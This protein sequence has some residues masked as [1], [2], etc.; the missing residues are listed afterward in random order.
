M[1]CELQYEGIV[2]QVGRYAVA[3]Q[4]EDF[5]SPTDTIPMSSIPVQFIV[6]IFS[7]SQSCSSNDQPE[8]VG[9]TP[10]DGSCIGAPFFSPWSAVIT[11]RIPYN[12]SAASIIELITASPLGLI[13]S[14]P[15]H[16]GNLRE[17]QIT[18]TW[19]PSLSQSG[20]NVFCFAA[21]DNTK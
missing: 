5:V 20:P 13:K 10:K 17:W 11:V 12:S 4:V 16:N 6:Q 21:R 7:S 9:S 1:Q 2:N 14:A 18:V 8:L 3:L 15:A 19:T